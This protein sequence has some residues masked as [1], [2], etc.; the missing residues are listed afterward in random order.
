MEE[1]EGDGSRRGVYGMH[2]HHH[3]NNHND[4]ED[5]SSRHS[6]GDDGAHGPAGVMRLHKG[7]WIDEQRCTVKVVPEEI[8]SVL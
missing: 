6:V 1:M 3:N 8:M 4:G 5:S 7:H 2:P